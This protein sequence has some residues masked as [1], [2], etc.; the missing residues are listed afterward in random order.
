MRLKGVLWKLKIFMVCL[1]LIGAG[2][3]FALP[4]GQMILKEMNKVFTL[5]VEKADWKLKEVHV[6][7]LKRTTRAQ[8][9][10]ALNAP[11]GTPMNQI[12]L[13]QVRENLLQLP[14]VQWCVVS[15]ALPNK[16]KIE[17]VEK[18]PI[19]LWQHKGVYHPL[20][21]MGNPIEEMK[22]SSEDLILVVGEDAPQNTIELL[23]ALD[24]VPDLSKQIQ[25]A[26]R[27]EGRRW[28]LYTV[29]NVKIL[30]PQD[31]MEQALK[32]LQKKD[33]SDGLLKKEV[34]SIDMR[35]AD[36]ITL[37]PKKKTTHKKGKK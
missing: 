36:R 6:V 32:R 30:L 18:T 28:N 15:R 26:T 16:L 35:L 9:E 29:E 3:F 2:V 10:A 31:Q 23:K 13:H 7:G 27:V 8:W 22:F 37:H 20:D 19:A 25:S 5:A 14:W 33:L 1:I 21:E 11:L 24:K 17:V 12:D 4:Q 34:D